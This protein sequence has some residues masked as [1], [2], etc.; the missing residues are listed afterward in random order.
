MEIEHFRHEINALFSRTS[1]IHVKEFE[2][3]PQAWQ[4]LHAA[5]A[6]TFHLVKALKQLPDFERMSEPQ[7]EE[8][9]KACRL[10]TFQK[11]ELRNAK[12]RSEY[13]I[14][15]IFWIELDDARRAQIEL[16]NYLAL[17]SIFMTKGLRQQFGEI[18]NSLST[19]ILDEQVGHGQ[20]YSAVLQKSISENMN[21]I[22]DLFAKIE[23]EVQKRLRYDEA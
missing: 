21:K 3:L 14:E 17:N 23:S 13:Y 1:K 16:N 18:N 11:D 22:S 12:G 10:Q 19:V 2:V 15:A 4:L 20:G 5:N 7:F 8:F 9:A 6:A